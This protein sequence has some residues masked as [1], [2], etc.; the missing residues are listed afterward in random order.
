MLVVC[1]KE[2]TVNSCKKRKIRHLKKK[3]DPSYIIS[4]RMN[5]TQEKEQCEITDWVRCG[6]EWKGMQW[7][8]LARKSDQGAAK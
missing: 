5:R 8:D 3:K 6:G 4:T 1:R 7:D 2:Y